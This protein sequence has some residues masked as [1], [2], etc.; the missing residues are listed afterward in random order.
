MTKKELKAKT[1]DELQSLQASYKK[2]AIEHIN[3][4]YYAVAIQYLNRAEYI[5]CVLEERNI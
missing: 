5:E 1:T 3:E 4:G 2:I